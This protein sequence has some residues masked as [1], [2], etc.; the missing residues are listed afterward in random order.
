ML[1]KLISTMHLE[2]T[3]VSIIRSGACEGL[4]VHDDVGTL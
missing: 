1:A 3:F 2:L 4:C